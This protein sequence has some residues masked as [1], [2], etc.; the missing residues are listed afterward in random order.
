MSERLND[1]ERRVKEW[2]E[3]TS[4]LSAPETSAAVLKTADAASARHLVSPPARQAA[5]LQIRA[6]RTKKA[7]KQESSGNAAFSGGIFCE[8]STGWPTHRP[9][10][11]TSQYSFVPEPGK[12]SQSREKWVLGHGQRSHFRKKCPKTGKNSTWDT[13]GKYK[14]IKNVPKP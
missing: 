14:M 7:S 4:R 2:K 6:A 9:D 13:F 12:M 8:D 3:S 10:K 1:T 5:A 11:G